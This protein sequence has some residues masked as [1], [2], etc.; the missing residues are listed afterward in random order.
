MLRARLNSV[1][2]DGKSFDTFSKIVRIVSKICRKMCV[3]RLT[4]NEFSFVN[5]RNA[6]EG[7]SLDLRIDQ[8]ELFTSYS[9]ESDSQTVDAI[10][11]EIQTDDLVYSTS[12]QDT[13]VEIKLLGKDLIPHLVV[14]LKTRGLIHEIPVNLIQKHN[15][16]DYDPPIV[17]IPSVGFFLPP[18]KVFYKIFSSIKNIGSKSITF[19]AN[20]NGELWLNGVMDQARMEIFVRD[21]VNVAIPGGNSQE[22]YGADEF[23]EVQL[24]LRVLYSFLSHLHVLFSKLLL[25]IVHGRTA[26]FSAKERDCQFHFYVNGLFEA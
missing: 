24:D 1:I 26:I 25:K 21:L 18:L 14:E 3:I 23:F 22:M 8:K 10:F 13:L 11:F 4:A 5:A 19:K 20:N 6:R 7:F 12:M 16:Q 15:W 17:G 2:A 9:L